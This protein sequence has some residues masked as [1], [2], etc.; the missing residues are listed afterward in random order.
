MLAPTQPIGRHNMDD[1]AMSDASGGVP[2]GYKMVPCTCCGDQASI[3]PDDA[4]PEDLPLSFRLCAGCFD[5]YEHWLERGA[6]SK[7]CLR[8][9]AGAA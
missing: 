4:D 7:V 9:S 2:E 8:H 1:D 3:V 6:G 5:C